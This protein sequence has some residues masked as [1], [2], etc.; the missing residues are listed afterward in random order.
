M[1]DLSGCCSHLCSTDGIEIPLAISFG[2]KEVQTS[3]YADCDAEAYIFSNKIGQ[4]LVIDIEAGQIRWF[5]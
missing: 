5:G 4:M 1:P 2:G 3:G